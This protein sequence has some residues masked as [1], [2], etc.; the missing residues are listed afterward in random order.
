MGEPHH[1]PRIPHVQLGRLADFGSD[2]DD[3]S[4]RRDSTEQ[5]AL[6]QVC[7]PSL[8]SNHCVTKM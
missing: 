4:L 8:G 7:T 2:D 5:E 6:R 1:G 3:D